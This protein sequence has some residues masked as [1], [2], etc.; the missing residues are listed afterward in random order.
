VAAT[1]CDAPRVRLR[2][3]SGRNHSFAK[4]ICCDAATGSMVL[5]KEGFAHAAT[6]PPDLRHT[7]AFVS[8]ELEARD[9]RRGLWGL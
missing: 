9:A 2:H 3:K 5:V 7:E 4:G 1:D 6:F 8:L